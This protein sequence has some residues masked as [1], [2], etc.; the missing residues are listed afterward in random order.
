MLHVSLHAF[1]FVLPTYLPVRFPFL[2]TIL[3]REPKSTT[4]P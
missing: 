2:L 4:D 3:P 1:L